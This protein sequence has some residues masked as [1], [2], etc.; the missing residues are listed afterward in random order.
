MKLL[1]CKACDDVV[2]LRDEWRECW[3]G[4]E[5]GVYSD[6]GDTV[7]VTDGAVMF[8]MCNHLRWPEAYPPH[9]CS[10]AWPYPEN[11]K[12]RRLRGAP[13]PT[14]RPRGLNGV[15]RRALLNL[16]KEEMEALP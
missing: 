6:D 12:I 2:V 8:G 15:G 14:A 10:N 9:E 16:T 1:H 3:C 5:G 11:Y 4:E 13:R 7:V